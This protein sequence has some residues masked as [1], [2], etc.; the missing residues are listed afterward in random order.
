M[1]IHLILLKN[2][3]PRQSGPSRPRGPW[4]LEGPPFEGLGHGPAAQCGP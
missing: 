3:N 4:P 2:A 1:L